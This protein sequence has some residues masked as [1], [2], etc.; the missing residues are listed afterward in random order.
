MHIVCGILFNHESPLRGIEFVS[1]KVVQH[2]VR[3]HHLDLRQPLR[4]GNLDARRDW[5]HAKDMVR[6]MWLMTTALASQDYVLASGVS[7]S[8]R[9]L[10]NL[11]YEQVGIELFWYGDGPNEYATDGSRHGHVLVTVDPEF[12][13]PNDIHTLLGDA[14]RA[15]TDL[16]WYPEFDFAELV[17]DMV[18]GCRCRLLPA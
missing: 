10:V 14:T 12:Y 2:A 5:S 4:L 8:V 16:G 7:H 17:A 3:Q 9:D 13:R 6:G 15:R 18:D 11:V 1:Q